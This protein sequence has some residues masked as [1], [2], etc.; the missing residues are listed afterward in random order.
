M[1]SDG[2]MYAQLD[3]F[4]PL[5]MTDRGP[6]YTCGMIARGMASSALG[7]TVVTPRIRNMS[8]DPARVVQTLPRWARQVPY[9]WVRQRAEHRKERA[10]L[11]QVDATELFPHGAYIWPDASL[12]TI[13]SLKERGIT[14]FREMINCH[15]ASAK[16]ILDEAYGRIG[17]TPCHGITEAS[18]LAEQRVLQEVDYIFCASP[19]VEASLI[20]NNTHP[21]KII[22]A[23]YGWEPARLYS[24]GKRLGPFDGLTFLFVGSVNIRKGGHLLLDY[25]ARSKVK[26]RLVLA[27]QIEDA[28]RDRCA[29]LLAREDVLALGYVPDVAPLYR[30]ADLFIFPSLE[31]GG[32]Q[33]TYEACACALPIITTPMG[34]G[35]IA[36]HGK[37][38]FIL[39]PY[40]ADG[41][42]SAIRALADDRRL[43]KAYS[44]SAKA[45]AEMFD[46]D[47]VAVRRRD[48]ILDRMTSPG[49]GSSSNP[50]PTN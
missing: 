23:S 22:S 24:S 27:G 40:D 46:W 11:S 26:G 35:R 36:R 39:D 31:E 13:R 12:A 3:V 30:S 6:A 14:V 2:T 41:W 49:P 28:I 21:T 10:F 1:N 43:R 33:V 32:P 15:R 5:P 16:T 4:M 17:A 34:A 29:T 50:E 44:Q 37:E 9:R 42:V 7:V 19:Q 48:Q 8:I 47:S 25:W 38:G 18:A 45:R 20:A